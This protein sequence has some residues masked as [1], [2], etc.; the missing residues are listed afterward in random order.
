MNWTITVHKW[1][2]DIERTLLTA[3][4]E[5]DARAKF[6]ARSTDYIVS[7]HPVLYPKDDTIEYIDR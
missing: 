7:I 2:G 1:N 6:E 4:T 3:P 5:D